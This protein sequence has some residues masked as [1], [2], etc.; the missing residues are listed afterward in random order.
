M[1]SSRVPGTPGTPLI[2]V[3]MALYDPLS[4]NT[5]VIYKSTDA[6]HPS[7]LRV[8]LFY[9]ATH[10]PKDDAEIAE[11]IKKFDSDG[12]GELKFDEFCA[13]ALEYCKILDPNA[14]HKILKRARDGDF[15]ADQQVTVTDRPE[16]LSAIAHLTY[17]TG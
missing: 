10:H 1:V 8:L 2:Q 16:Y 12:N 11:V 15:L 7:P 3:P 17:T 5:I 14:F 6:Q 4:H 9:W 13:S